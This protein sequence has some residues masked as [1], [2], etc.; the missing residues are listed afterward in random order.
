MTSIRLLRQ[1]GS[2]AL[3]RFLDRVAFFLHLAA[4]TALLVGGIGVGNAV[5]GYIDGK[6]ASID[7]DA[8]AQGLQMLHDMR[9]TDESMGKNTNYEWGPINE[10]FAAG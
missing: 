8:T 2:P 5:A 4:V 7:N 1:S 3:Q 6:T 9:W 10:A